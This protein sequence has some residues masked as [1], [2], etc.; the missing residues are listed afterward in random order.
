MQILE[1]NTQS[2]VN[3]ALFALAFRPFFIL[4]GLSA[5]LLLAFWLLAMSLG[6]QITATIPPV[7]WH[8]HEMIFAYS[9]AV[10]AGFLLTAA[11]NWS[12]VQTLNGKPLILLA[13]LWLAPRVLVFM[14][15]D[16][17]WVA[18]IELSFFVFLAIAI[19]CPIVR[20]RQW[21]NSVFIALIVCY[22]VA[23]ALYYAEFISGLSNGEEW[24]IHYG[25]G[26]I[27]VIITLMAGRVVG[28]FI[29][30]GLNQPVKNYRWANLLAVMGT[31][32]FMAGQFVLPLNSLIV[33]ALLAAVGHFGRLLGW[34]HHDIWKNPLLWVLYLGYGWLLAG[35]VLTAMHL[36]GLLAESL[37]IHGFT[38]G[39][40]GS[41]TLGMM[42]RVA[43]GHTGRELQS[44]ASINLAFVLINMAA[45]IRVGL[46]MLAPALSISWIQ[47]SGSL[48]LLAF[49]LFCRV[50]IPLLI[51]ARVDGQPG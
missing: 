16:L 38:V 39:A 11:R 49:L 22:G 8:A 45:L 28:F 17:I 35:F 7:Y 46:P 42:A 5:V 29:T 15:L 10:I 20:A 4:A 30:R 34:Y 33:I 41:I 18:L 37:A 25:L 1:P 32:V 14:P 48:W 13:A 2:P 27:I 9:S 47:L 12:G 36:A 26:V 19:A 43:L 50:Y 31:A 21:N 44:A 24:G 6:W 40:I 51:T 3:F 23:D